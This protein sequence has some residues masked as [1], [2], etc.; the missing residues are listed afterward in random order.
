MRKNNKWSQGLSSDKRLS[1]LLATM[2]RSWIFI[3]ELFYLLP[4][5]IYVL[6]EESQSGSPVCTVNFIGAVFVFVLKWK[7]N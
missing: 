7:G 6:R 4:L 2:Y 1:E 5:S 3:F